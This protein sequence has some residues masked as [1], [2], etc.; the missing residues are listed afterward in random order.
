MLGTTCIRWLPTQGDV[1]H[2]GAHSCVSSVLPSA[3]A[4]ALRC[5]RRAFPAQSDSEGRGEKP[6]VELCTGLGKAGRPSEQLETIQMPISQK[7]EKGRR[8]KSLPTP[9]LALV[10]GPPKGVGRCFMDEK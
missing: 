9:T 4:V 2:P 7:G 3:R 1:V 10:V 8:D 6:E 5:F